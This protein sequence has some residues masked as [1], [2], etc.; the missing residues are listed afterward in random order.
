MDS[1]DLI[2]YARRAS[3]LGTC[4]A[5]LEHIRQQSECLAGQV[6]QSKSSLE[7]AMLVPALIRPAQASVICDQNSLEESYRT[8]HV[9]LNMLSEH[10]TE[11]CVVAT[12]TA[13]RVHTLGLQPFSAFCG[14]KTVTARLCP[15]LGALDDETKFA[16]TQ[17]L[18]L[19]QLIDHAT[20]GVNQLLAD[21]CAN[22]RQANKIERWTIVG[23]VTR[24]LSYL[25]LPSKKKSFR[26]MRQRP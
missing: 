24:C 6:R 2:E 3:N 20:W 22:R 10:L 26:A 11:L 25:S 21:V 5:R 19:E 9:S 1:N 18:A 23:F 7:A 4:W 8:T 16:E 17:L 14:L 13:D 12:T 15:A